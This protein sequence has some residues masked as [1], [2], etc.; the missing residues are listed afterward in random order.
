VAERVRDSIVVH[1]DP[2]TVMHF[3]ADFENYPSWQEDIRDVEI[4]ETDD[5][6][7]ATKVRYDVTSGP[8]AARLVLAY[9]YD[10][11]AM[12]WELVESDKIKVNTGAYLLEDLGDGSTQLTYEL[13]AEPKIRVPGLLRRQISRKVITSALEGVKRTIE[14][15]A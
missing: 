13:E 5:D 6:G 4:L 2:D 8:L 11:N 15:A 14:G 1:A 9:T 10:D 3:I 12:R 7:W